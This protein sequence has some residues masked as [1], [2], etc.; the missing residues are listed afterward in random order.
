MSTMVQNFLL[1]TVR[2]FI[3]SCD[4][5]YLDIS[6]GINKVDFLLHSHVIHRISLILWHRVRGAVL[7][8]WVQSVLFELRSFVSKVES[9][10]SVKEA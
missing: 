5:A 4:M 10:C 1:D 2:A 3:S 9:S 6:S 8:L 7:L